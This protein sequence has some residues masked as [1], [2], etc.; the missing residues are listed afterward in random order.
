MLMTPSAPEAMKAS[1]SES[2]PL[3]TVMSSPMARFSWSTRSTEPPA[4]LIDRTFGYLDLRC[5]TT[6]T[7]ISTAQRE[8][9]ERG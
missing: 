6:G 3:R 9:I 4:S 2:S 8:G 1:V 7:L 5:S